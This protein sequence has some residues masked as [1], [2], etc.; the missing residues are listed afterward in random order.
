MIPAGATYRD[1]VMC[2]ED[3][4]RATTDAQGSNV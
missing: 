3:L 2:D 4:E 1:I